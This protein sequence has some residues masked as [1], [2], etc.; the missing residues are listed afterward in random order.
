MYID[1]IV[2][3]LLL[4]YFF[5]FITRLFIF[6]LNSNQHDKQKVIQSESESAHFEDGSKYII[7]IIFNYIFFVLK[8]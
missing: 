1:L 5:F 3:V 6:L 7:I 8:I 4:L 2:E